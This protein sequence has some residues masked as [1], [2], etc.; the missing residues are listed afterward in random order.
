MTYPVIYCANLVC[1]AQ[2]AV[3]LAIFCTQLFRYLREMFRDK[4]VEH[5][6]IRI[7]RL[8]LSITVG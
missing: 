2:L 6:L 1:P 4:T 3:L 8:I 5:A 7:N